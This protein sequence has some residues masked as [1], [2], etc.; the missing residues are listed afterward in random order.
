MCK[1]MLG[2]VL[3]AAFSAVLAFG[4]IGTLDLHWDTEPVSADMVGVP[5][6]LHW[7]AAQVGADA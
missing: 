4:T 1:R 7:D 2:S 5:P 6:D 3:A